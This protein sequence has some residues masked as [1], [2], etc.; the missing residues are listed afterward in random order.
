MRGAQGRNRTTDTRIFSRLR[1]RFINKINKLK[2]RKQ[3]VLRS[4]LLDSVNWHIIHSKNKSVLKY[5]RL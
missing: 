3:S 1:D 2:S 5:F 4:V